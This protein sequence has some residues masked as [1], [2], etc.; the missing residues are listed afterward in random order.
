MVGCCWYLATGADISRMLD[1][2]LLQLPHTTLC[3]ANTALR[4]VRAGSRSPARH[5]CILATVE[6]LCRHVCL[7]NLS[8][9]Q[10]QNADAVLH[11]ASCPRPHAGRVESGRNGCDWHRQG[12]SK[13]SCTTLALPR[14][15]GHQNE[16]RKRT[17]STTDTRTEGTRMDRARLEGIK[18]EGIRTESAEHNAPVYPGTRVCHGPYGLTKNNDW[19]TLCAH[20]HNSPAATVLCRVN[21]GQPTHA[22]SARTI[23]F[24]SPQ[25]RKLVL[26][27]KYML[28]AVCCCK[29][30]LHA[31]QSNHVYAHRRPLYND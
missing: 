1:G 15:K 21:L 11:V 20:N 3:T 25:A 17:E 22:N 18:T 16:H 23:Y 19:L 12:V 31:K 24:L 9:V 10:C 6:M 8:S 13:A 30:P 14:V 4:C 2:M 26:P 7:S 27:A 29:N 5:S 28:D